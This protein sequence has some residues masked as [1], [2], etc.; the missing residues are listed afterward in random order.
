MNHS[1][2]WSKTVSNKP[3]HVAQIQKLEVLRILDLKKL[4]KTEEN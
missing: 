1:K 4:S 2:K 3:R